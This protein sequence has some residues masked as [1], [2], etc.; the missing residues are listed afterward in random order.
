MKLVYHNSVPLSSN[1][2]QT[3][4]SSNTYKDK[5]VFLLPN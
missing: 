5:C 1:S 2:I 4:T 3:W